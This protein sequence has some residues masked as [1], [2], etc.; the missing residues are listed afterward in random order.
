MNCS[1]LVHFSQC[2]YTIK[3]IPFSVTDTNWRK[4]KHS[5]PAETDSRYSLLHH[6]CCNLR[7]WRCQRHFWP[8]KDMYV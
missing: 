5:S 7:E 4:E 8:R 2:I 6:C 1:L 3:T